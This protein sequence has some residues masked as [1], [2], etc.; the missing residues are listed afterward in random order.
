MT[1]EGPRP[2]PRGPVCRIVSGGG[3][4]DP[5]RDRAH[6]THA[7]GRDDPAA[8]QDSVDGAAGPHARRRAARRP[9]TRTSNRRV[10][11]RRR[12]KSQMAGHRPGT[13][14][15]EEPSPRGR[16]AE[17][18]PSTIHGDIMQNERDW[19]GLPQRRVGHEGLEVTLQV[20]TRRSADSHLTAT[21]PRRSA[22]PF[23][24]TQPLVTRMPSARDQIRWA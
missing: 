18:A 11:D 13:C 5:S 10:R 3:N 17:R 24:T 7:G 19:F 4:P 16:S 6:D 8:L 14:A 23:V 9:G 22:P 1:R 15:H 12:D 21:A 2:A 20:L